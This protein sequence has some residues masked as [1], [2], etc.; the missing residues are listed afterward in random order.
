MTS[1]APYRPRLPERAPT[2]ADL[3]ERD[4][5]Q[6]LVAESLPSVRASAET[7]RNG[8]AAFITL[9]TTAVVLKG[10]STTADLTTGWRVA[11][12]ILIGVGLGLAV[13]GL[14]Q[15]LAAQAGARPETLT[16]T[17]IHARYG[18]IQAH[19]VAM[20][21][22]A[23]QRLTVARYAVAAALASLLAGIALTWWAPA[24]PPNP[25]AYLRVGHG[26]QTT[27]GVLSAAS[28]GQ[29]QVT[30]AGRTAPTTIDLTEVT[31]L[32]VVARC[33]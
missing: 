25:P 29:L 4:R 19:Q 14:W 12:T 10:R 24:A 11:I 8:L 13:V 6:K 18:S 2:P 16:L 15:A 3:A 31:S 1:P 28:N 33:D 5:F 23:A 26:Q 32:A 27:C 20:A 7:W 17:D 22:R 21:L 30:P 9:V